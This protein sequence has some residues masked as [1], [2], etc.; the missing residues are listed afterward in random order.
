MVHVNIV[1]M[2]ETGSLMKVFYTDTNPAP[3]TYNSSYAHTQG[4]FQPQREKDK[5]LYSC[6]KEKKKICIPAHPEAAY[7]T[8]IGIF[9]FTKKSNLEV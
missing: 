2:T 8:Q 4:K 6:P 9:F 1:E 3:P 7:H 5:H